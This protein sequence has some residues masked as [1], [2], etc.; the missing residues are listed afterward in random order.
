MK[1]LTHALT[2]ADYHAES[3]NSV[4]VTDGDKWGRFDRT[5]AW[6]EGELRQCDPHMCIWVTH[7]LVMDENARRAAQESAR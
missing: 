6:L 2:R 5:G 3:A 1:T 7:E 4:R